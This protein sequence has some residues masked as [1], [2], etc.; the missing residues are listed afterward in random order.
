MN[1]ILRTWFNSGKI[2]ISLSSPIYDATVIKLSNNVARRRQFGWLNNVVKCPQ[3]ISMAKFDNKYQKLI[4][5]IGYE[6]SQFLFYF[7]VCQKMYI[8]V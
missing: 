4:S 5:S 1:F 2:N 3:I 8:N 6:L 7:F